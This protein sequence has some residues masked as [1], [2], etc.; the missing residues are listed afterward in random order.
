MCW[1]FSTGLATLL[2]PAPGSRRLTFVEAATGARALWLLAAVVSGK[3]G[4]SLE[5]KRMRPWHLFPWLLLCWAAGRQ[6]LGFSPFAIVP[7]I[8]SYG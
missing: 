2:Q 5:S 8:F 7:V 3:N 4:R 6:G 1:M